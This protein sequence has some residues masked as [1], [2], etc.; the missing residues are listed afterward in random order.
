MPAREASRL[1][2]RHRRT[3]LAVWREHHAWCLR[4]SMQRL[5][6]RPAGT[7]LT[8]LVMGFALA[9]PLAFWLVLGNVQQ[10]AGTLGRAQALNVFMQADANADSAATLAERL[11]RRADIAKV[12]V[13]TPAE[14][15]RELASMQ[16]FA[17]ALDAL[18]SNPLPYV[19]LIEPRAHASARTVAALA[20]HV[21]ALPGVDQVRNDGTW[22][23]RLDALMDVGRRVAT[24]MALLLAVAAVLVVGN[25]V[26]LDIQARAEELAVLRLV[27][28]SAAFVRRPY[29]Y[30]G[31]WYGLAS[32]L[33]AAL[34]VLLLEGVLAGPLAR[35]ARSYGGQLEVAGLAW[36]QLLLA[37]VLAAAL[38]WLGARLVSARWLRRVE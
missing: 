9:L 8:V 32:G 26:R 7:F 34:L 15:M 29:L 13:K 24:A 2:P 38:G 21:R 10:L 31:L 28:A 6:A 25:S 22:R 37:P 33:V 27:G 3:Y 20:T 14:G 23:Q 12:T 36:W 5:A 35:L 18:D 17:Q 1:R 19:L 30:S 11:R 16:G 4:A